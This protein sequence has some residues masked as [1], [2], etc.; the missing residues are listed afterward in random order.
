MKNRRKNILET[1]TLLKGLEV[2]IDEGYKKLIKSQFGSNPGRG[3]GELIQNLIDSYPSDS[4]MEKRRGE[5]ITHR[6]MISITD[7]G[8]GLDRKK[9]KLLLTLG[10]TDKDK[11]PS[12]IGMFGIGFFSI[13]NPK[14]GTQKVKVTTNCEGHAVEISFLVKESEKRPEIRTNIL[15]K[16]TKYKTRIEVWFDDPGSVDKCIYFAKKALKYYPCNI[17]INGD[18]FRSV[19][20]TA[21]DEKNKIFART[22]M[23]GFLSGRLNW[24]DYVSILCKYEYIIRLPVNSFPNG[25]HNLKGNLLDFYSKETPYVPGSS[26]TINNNNLRVTISRDSFYLDKNF[27]E[28]VTFLNE[29]LM[30]KL[31][32][33]LTKDFNKDVIVANQF[34]FR[35]KIGEY[36]Q[37]PT[38]FKD[39]KTTGIVIKMLAQAKVYEV[40]DSREKYSLFDFTKMLSEDLPLYFSEQKT[41][42][43]WLGGN[44]KHDFIVLPNTCKAFNGAPEFYSKLFRC[45]FVDI[46]D[47]DTIRINSEKIKELVDRMIVNKSALSPECR[48][49]GEKKLDR[50]QMALL[51]EIS[52]ILENEEIKMV[53]SETIDIPV[54]NI[55]PTFFEVKEKGAYISTGLFNQGGEPLS[56]QFV[57]NFEE[58]ERK[59]TDYYYEQIDIILG[60]RLDHP[61]I[62][63]LIASDSKHRAYYTM[64]Y[65][66]H[67]LAMCQKLLVPYSPLYHLVKE[68]T[69]SGMRKALIDHLINSRVA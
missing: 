1:I 55:K 69:A 15:R 46:V 51:L 42:L 23:S 63:F 58:K 38:R 18:S 31:K 29:M 9:I 35:D 64:T 62:Q 34:I 48:F 37:D 12:K 49:V 8:E 25:G 50:D 21:R 33:I 57:T 66:A 40:C 60:I 36:L 65:V 53:I 11:D 26:A 24:K 67:E 16:R 7:Y 6:N 41:N 20:A 39:N 32:D 13:F 47:L 30:E 61:V 56:D 22:N 54:R 43:V 44:F 28:S 27:R 59:E 10:G 19:W 45:I 5:I 14:L 3:F 68:K 52:S 17:K 2:D 4:P